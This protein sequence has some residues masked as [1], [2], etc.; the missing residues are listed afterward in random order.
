MICKSQV[1]CRANL[2]SSWLYWLYWSTSTLTYLLNLI[3]QLKINL[4]IFNFAFLLNLFL[5]SLNQSC[6]SSLTAELLATVPC[7]HQKELLRVARAAALSIFN[8]LSSS[9]NEFSSPQSSFKSRLRCLLQNFHYLII[10]FVF[11]LWNEIGESYLFFFFRH[12]FSK[13]FSWV[14]SL[15]H[16]W[17]AKC[18]R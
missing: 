13:F 12:Y 14:K 2:L 6:W 18:R 3:I 8:W 16:R 5:L 7:I 4:S 9:W 11:E 17:R 1:D 15:L 10:I